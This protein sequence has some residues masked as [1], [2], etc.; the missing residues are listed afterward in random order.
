[1]V[2]HEAAQEPEKLQIASGFTLKAATRLHAVQVAID[3]ELQQNR[4]VE[5]GP[6][7]RCWLDTIEPEAGQIERIDKGVDHANGVLLV[8]PVVEALRQKRRLPPICPFDEPLHD[9]PRRIMKGSIAAP[10]F[11]HSQGQTRPSAAC[12]W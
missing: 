12:S 8:D 10:V 2:R 1:V 7:G 9:H 11:S 3:V 5:A 4:G 6:S